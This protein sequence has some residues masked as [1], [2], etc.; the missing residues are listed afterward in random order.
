MPRRHPQYRRLSLALAGA[1]AVVGLGAAATP[2]VAAPAPGASV[3]STA[4]TDFWVTFSR[5]AN[6][7]TVQVFVTGATTTGTVT[8]PGAAPAPFTTTEGQVTVLDAPA[9]Y[10]AAIQAMGSDGTFATGVHVQT[11]APVTVYGLNYGGSSSDGFV[12]SPVPAL[13][14]DYRV[15]SVPTTIGDYGSRVTVV[16]TQD[17]TE[18]TVVPASALADRTAGTPYTVTLD[19]GQVYSLAGTRSG[20]DVSGTTVSASAPVAVF[21]GADCVNIGLGACDLVTEQMWPVDQWGTSFILSRFRSESGGNPVRVLADRDGTELRVDGAVVATLD[22]GEI[23]DGTLMTA[24]G[25]SAAVVTADQPVLV[26]QQM[27][28]GQY[29][30]DGR[31]TSGDPATMLVPPYQQFLDR[32][33][34]STPAGRFSFNAINVVVP[35]AQLGSFRL[36]GAPVDAAQFA[37]VAGTTF[38]A[39]Q[40]LVAD[41]THTV[42]ADAPFGAFA[43]GAN[44][45][46]SYAYAGG[47]GLT[48][49]GRVARVAPVDPDAVPTS[50]RPDEEVCVPVVVQDADGEPVAGVRVDL[51]VAGANAGA[52]DTRNTDADGRASLCY[53]PTEL[54]E[55]VL[56]VTSGTADAQF[57]VVVT[58]APEISTTDLG[59]LV[60]GRPAAV[61]VRAVGTPAPTFAVTAGALPAG[62]TLDEETGEVTG[63][64]TTA[65]P[66]SATVTAT[67]ENGTDSVVLTGDVAAAPVATGAVVPRLVVG[68][69][70][71]VPAPASGRPAPAFVVSAGALPAGLTLDAAT[72]VVSGT[73]TQSGSWSATITATNAVGSTDVVLGGEVLAASADP[74]PAAP[75][76]ADAA[77]AAL[78]ATGTQALTTSALALALLVLGAALVLVRRHRAR[79]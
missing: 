65:G 30:Q 63:T 75:T 27:V 74:T 31:T 59:V 3:L 67:N 19:A 20:D 54:G 39:A 33:T 48:P 43:Y 73:P 23:W 14:T 50:G 15:L 76:S 78:S 40:L 6:P 60:V 52:T 12:A 45:F 55:D 24:G 5:N 28:S 13:G 61:A 68:E 16:G 4:G 46:N 77:P 2:T 9:G 36:D 37:P 1:L 26:S 64:P 47:A 17:D 34:F 51:A 57:T 22:A 58:S 11:E 69:A 21:A 29:V 42:S 35:T 38:S 70:V 32:Y 56:T 79:G 41:G 66:W 25:N 18:V 7:P 72:G 8:W 49:V 71:T 44:N 62:L 53:T 10:A